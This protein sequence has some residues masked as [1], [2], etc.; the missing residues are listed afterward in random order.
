MELL[1]VRLSA[2]PPNL[3]ITNRIPL[4]EPSSSWTLPMIVPEDRHHTT[5]LSQ[6]KDE[7]SHRRRNKNRI[8]LL[9][10]WINITL[11]NVILQ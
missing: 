10:N 4:L 9:T 1:G 8:I 3:E 6:V 11:N 2:K 7:L 5:H